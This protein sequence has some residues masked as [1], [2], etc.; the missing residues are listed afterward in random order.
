M[1]SNKENDYIL[2]GFGLGQ[3]GQDVGDGRYHCTL[4]PKTFNGDLKT[5]YRHVMSDEHLKRLP[6]IYCQQLLL[7]K[8]SDMALVC[9]KCQKKFS[10]GDSMKKHAD[11]C[12]VPKKRKEPRA[13][14]P[15]RRPAQ[16]VQTP[17]V[18][19]EVPPP[20]PDFPELKGNPRFTEA[21]RVA[22]Q[23]FNFDNLMGDPLLL[24]FVRFVVYLNCYIIPTHYP[25]L[26]G[27]Y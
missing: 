26:V 20:D 4:C 17:A 10:R 23:P 11:T 22:A 6:P 2:P 9:P 27:V 5:K 15:R 19:E 14:R 24:E 3:Y 1:S 25:H 8:D 18:V 7:L 16:V 21:V 12:G 13:S